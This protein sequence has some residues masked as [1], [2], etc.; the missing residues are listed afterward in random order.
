MSLLSFYATPGPLT[1]PCEHA[2]LFHDLPTDISALVQIVQN[3]LLHVF[4]SE[5]YGVQLTDEQKRT[6]NV[7]SIREKL[8]ILRATDPRPLTALRQPAERQVGNCRDFTLMLVSM[9]RHQGV[10]ARARCG[11]GR[12]FEPDHGEDHWVAE[13]WN[14]DQHRWIL[15]DAQLDQLQREVLHLPFDPLD[16][17]R[18]QFVVAGQAWQTCRSG[19]DQPEKYG[20]FDMHGWWFIFG[21]VVREALA[22]NKIEIL[23]W[24]YEVGYFA[25]RLE[26]PLP[27]EG[28]E[29]AEYDRLAALTVAG[30]AVF[31][32]LR[33]LYEIEPRLHVPAAWLA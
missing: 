18:D 4:W 8:A 10:P 25:H 28:P 13:Y 1:D 11:F 22:F 21:N 31:D 15:V 7:R 19:A 29:L 6:L 27:D 2:E 3:N 24:D 17:P 14:A 32:D 5:R 30:D 16:V 23:P 12:Y 20:I 26:D 9:L 33:H